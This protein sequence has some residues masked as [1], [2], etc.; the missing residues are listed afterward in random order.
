MKIRKG[1]TAMTQAET[2]MKKKRSIKAEIERTLSKEQSDALWNKAT[3]RLEQLLRKYADLPAGVRAHTDSYIFPSAA[4]YLTA[5]DYMTE[6]QAYAV[7][8]QAAIANTT[9]YGKMLAHLMKLPFMRDLFIR[10]WDPLTKKK[11]GK[12]SGFQN[13]FYPKKKA[14]TAWT[15]LPARIAGILQSSAALNSP[16]SSA[17]MTSG[18]TAICPGSSL[19]ERARLEKARNAVISAYAR[20]RSRDRVQMKGSGYDG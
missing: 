8:E 11:F 2:I 3:A 19:S 16:G 5:K 10:M 7:I 12:D 17:R 18:D 20:H 15:S 1:C 14:N 13:R 4:I 6:Q 9:R